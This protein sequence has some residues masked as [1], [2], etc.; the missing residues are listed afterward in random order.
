MGCE[1][2][3]DDTHSTLLLPS[4]S[5]NETAHLSLHRH[6]SRLSLSLSANARLFKT[7]I[8]VAQCSERCRGQWS[9]PASRRD[10][11]SVSLVSLVS[12]V[13]RSC[14]VRAPLLPVR[15]ATGAP[16]AGGHGRLACPCSHE[17]KVYSPSRR[18]VSS[19][20][21]SLSTS[22]VGRRPH[23]AGHYTSS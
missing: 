3:Q 12:L 19:L 11:V 1:P 10:C 20:L 13:D 16:Q 6:L 2:G 5:I 22:H 17:P 21:P 7:S 8:P 4:V 23:P 14:A 18:F 9:W 15:P